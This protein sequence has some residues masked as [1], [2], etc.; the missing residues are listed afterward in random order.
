MAGQMLAAAECV[1]QVV[2]VGVKPSLHEEFIDFCISP[3][4]PKVMA[5]TEADKYWHAISQIK[6][7]LEN[8]YR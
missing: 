6:D 3:L 7:C 8:E 2:Q 4:S 5:I 1:P